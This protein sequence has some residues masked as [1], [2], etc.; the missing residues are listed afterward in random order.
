MT[1]KAKEIVIWMKNNIIDIDKQKIIASLLNEDF[2]D[3]EDGLQMECAKRVNA[4]YIITRNLADFSNSS[5]PAILPGDF[6]KI[7]PKGI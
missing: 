4:S 3:I 1:A 7:S 2:S 5:V 6:L